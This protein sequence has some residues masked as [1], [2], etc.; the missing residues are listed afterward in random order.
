VVDD[1][2]SLERGV[3]VLRGYALTHVL[4]LPMLSLQTIIIITAII[5]TTNAGCRL[6]HAQQQRAGDDGAVG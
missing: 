4:S 5:I 2:E 6:A 3:F 1:D